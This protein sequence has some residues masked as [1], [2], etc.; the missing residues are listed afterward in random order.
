M[1]SGMKISKEDVTL[2]RGP[3]HSSQNYA[4]ATNLVAMLNRA[5]DKELILSREVKTPAMS[6]LFA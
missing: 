5:G 4:D 3:Y 6:A 2:E 1:S